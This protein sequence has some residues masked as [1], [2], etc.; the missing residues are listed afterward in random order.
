MSLRNV[1]KTMFCG[2]VEVGQG[3]IPPRT[4]KQVGPPMAEPETTVAGV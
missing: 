1:S 2:S 3:E 4:K